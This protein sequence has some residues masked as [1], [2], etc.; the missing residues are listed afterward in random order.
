ML[1]HHVYNIIP[2]VGR[3]HSKTMGGVNFSISLLFSHLLGCRGV[4]R[5]TTLFQIFERTPA[6]KVNPSNTYLYVKYRG[7]I[8]HEVGVKTCRFE[9]QSGNCV[10]CTKS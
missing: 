6:W 3:V 10:R 4:V 7:S 9:M 1:Y 5:Y 8:W 2:G